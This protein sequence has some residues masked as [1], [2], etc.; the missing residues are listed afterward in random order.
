LNTRTGGRLLP[1]LLEYIPSLLAGG[2]TNDIL[3][4]SGEVR[5]WTESGRTL[6]TL[7]FPTPEVKESPTSYPPLDD[8]SKWNDGQK[9]TT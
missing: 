2:Q 5:G 4:R 9:L 8:D 6:L 7:A 1:K 3:V